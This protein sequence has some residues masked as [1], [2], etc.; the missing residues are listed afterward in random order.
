M[1]NLVKGYVPEVYSESRDYRVFLRLL[2]VLISVLKDKVDR[3]PTLYSSDECPKDLLYLLAD[4]VGY[5]LDSS[6]TTQ[7]NRMIISNYPVMLRNRGSRTGLK[8]AAALSLNSKSSSPSYSLDNILIE[9]DFDKG[10][11]KIYYPSDEELD[12]DLIEAVRPVGSRVQ[13]IASTIRKNTEEVD[14]KVDVF[15]DT[16]K[17]TKERTEVG[18][19]KVGFGDTGYQE[20]SGD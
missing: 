20:S 2:S 19:S 10:L 1:I 4:M 7:S 5:S 11:I 17:W 13:Y 15:K 3:V 6:R 8:M 16:D 9:Y 12:F 14:V 18:K